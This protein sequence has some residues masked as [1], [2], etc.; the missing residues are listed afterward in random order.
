MSLEAC[1]KNFNGRTLDPK[2][3]WTLIAFFDAFKVRDRLRA[4]SPS[5]A[6]YVLLRKNV[7]GERRLHK[8]GRKIG[9]FFREERG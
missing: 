3:L 9:P 4:M 1:Q 5:T 7:S 8:H 6:N 2:S